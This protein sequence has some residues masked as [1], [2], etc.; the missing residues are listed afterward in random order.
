MDKADIQDQSKDL[1]REKTTFEKLS[2]EVKSTLF[3]ALFLLLKEDE[4][5]IYLSGFIS[6][7]HFL[8]FIWFPFH[9]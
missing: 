9:P 6:I 8:Q 3:E 1:D 7:I 5:S 4:I 2:M